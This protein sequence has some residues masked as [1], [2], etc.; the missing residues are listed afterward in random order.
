MNSFRFIERAGSEP[1]IARQRGSSN[2]GEQV[3]QET[4]HYDP[5]SA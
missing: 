4:L 5:A 3:V 2:G 1:E